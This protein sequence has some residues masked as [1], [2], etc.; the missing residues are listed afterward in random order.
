MRCD[1]V[2]DK[3]IEL[4]ESIEPDSQVS[5]EDVFQ[6]HDFDTPARDRAFRLDRV[7]PQAPAVEMMTGLGSGADPYEVAFDLSVVYVEGPGSTKR[8]LQDGDKVVDQLRALV[9]EQQIRTISISPGSEILDSG[10]LWFVNWG[11]TVT[12]DRRDQ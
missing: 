4:V 2:R 6:V 1:E 3:I 10:G 12:Y 5:S 7:S 9:A 8:R 11:I